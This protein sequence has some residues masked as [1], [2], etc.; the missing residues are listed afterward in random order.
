MVNIVR[1]HAPW[2]SHIF[3]NLVSSLQIAIVLYH[4]FRDVSVATSLGR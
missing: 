4:L 1:T 2:V 3:T